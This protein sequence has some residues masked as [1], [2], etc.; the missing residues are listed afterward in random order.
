LKKRVPSKHP[1]IDGV[2]YYD[3]GN[4]FGREVCI[5]PA[6]WRARKMAVLERDR[7]R[8]QLAVEVGRNP[9]LIHVVPNFP[10]HGWTADHK[11]KRGLGGSSRNDNM[12]N[13][14]ATC[15]FC[16]ALAHDTNVHNR[17]SQP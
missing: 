13:L 9:H 4:P 15:D 3:L 14:R 1:V 6:A 10:H 5:T 11:T 17:E 8:C 7:F 16:H 12:N 2:V